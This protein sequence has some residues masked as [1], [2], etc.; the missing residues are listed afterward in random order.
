MITQLK[1]SE[2]KQKK[3]VNWLYDEIKAAL[4][5]RSELEDR[6]EKWIRNFEGKPEQEV[7]NFPFTNASN[8]VAPISS[9]VVNA[10]VAREYATLFG[11]TPFWTVIALNKNWVDHAL[12]TQRLLDY[13]QR[14]EMELHKKLVDWLYIKNI[15]GTGIAKVPWITDLKPRKRYREDGTIETIIHNIADGPRFIPI[16][17]QDFIIPVT[18]IQNIQDCQ[19]VAHRFRLR[20]G[21]IQ[22]RARQKVYMN[23]EKMENFFKSEAERITSEQERLEHLYRTFEIKEYELYEIWCN[24]DYDDCGYE[25]SCVFTINFDSM[26]LLRA[27]LNPFDHG[28]RPFITTPCFPRANRIYGIGYGQK[29]E[30]LQEGLTTAYNQAIDN[31]SLANARCLKARRGKGIKPGI[32]IYPGKVFLVDEM[33]DIDVFQLGEIYPSAHVIIRAMHDLVERDTGVSSYQLGKESPIVG[34]SATA[35]STLALIQEGN[36]LFNFLLNNDRASLSDVAYQVFNLYKQF[37]PFGLTFT[38]LGEDG[39]FIEEVWSGVPDE[40]VRR[41]LIFQLTASSAHVNK[42]VERESWLQISQ[43]LMAYYERLVQLATIGTDMSVAPEMRLL[44]LKIAESGH[45]VMEKILERF[46]L[47]NVD[48]LL[49]NLREVIEGSERLGGLG[50]TI[51]GTEA[52]AGESPPPGG[53]PIISAPLKGAA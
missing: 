32:K 42:I 21:T 47:L 9:S 51:P 38:L 41:G 22:Q 19:W 5:G 6:W 48:R 53:V 27:I 17:I 10:V 20:W 44:S 33:D 45:I 24:Y 2:D 16:P 43:L 28:L 13:S 36:T 30:R 29:L 14:F 49:V 1:L 34:T 35:T 25:E 4:S 46:D 7:K 15:L 8:I 40:D 39:R 31:A 50:G 37:K 18:S 52:V 23:V 11:V 3:I 26:T 12:P